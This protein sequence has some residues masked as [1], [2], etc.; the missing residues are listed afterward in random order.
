[1]RH[2]C[3]DLTHEWSSSL[4]HGDNPR[5]HSGSG[6]NRL[7]AMVAKDRLTRRSLVPSMLGAIAGIQLVATVTGAEVAMTWLASHSDEWELAVVTLEHDP[8]QLEVVSFARGSKAS[9]KIVVFGS[10]VSGEI[11]AECLRCGADAAF[12]SRRSGD[13]VAWLDQ[14]GAPDVA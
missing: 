12:S 7:K 4:T 1:M 10:I 6:A 14:L 11:R 9:A 5:L 2:H 8:A 13:F 3:A